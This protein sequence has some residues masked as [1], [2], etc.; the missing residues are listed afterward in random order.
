MAASG[1][2]VFTAAV[3]SGSISLVGCLMG[4]AKRRVQCGMGARRWC[5]L[6]PR[7]PQRLH[8]VGEF[9]ADGDVL[10]G[11]LA[12]RLRSPCTR[13]CACGCARHSCVGASMCAT[14]P[15]NKLSPGDLNQRSF[16]GPSVNSIAALRCFRQAL[17]RLRLIDTA[18]VT[19][20]INRI[21]R[22]IGQ[23]VGTL[24]LRSR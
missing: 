22:L 9:G 14:R 16:P 2:K 11:R 1:R 17:G 23:R 12:R 15:I 19:F 20:S 13:W 6:L 18:L 7:N 3:S 21:N 4:N 24:L 10:G 8:A 5:L